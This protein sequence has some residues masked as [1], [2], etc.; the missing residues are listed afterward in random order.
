[1]QFRP[2]PERRVQGQEVL[3]AGDALDGAGDHLVG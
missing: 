1:V 2:V 3:V